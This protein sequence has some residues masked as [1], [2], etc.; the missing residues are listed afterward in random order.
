MN[1]SDRRNKFYIC[2]G[3]GIVEGFYT[4]GKQNIPL[5]GICKIE[6]QR[7]IKKQGHNSLKIDF[8]KPPEGIGVYLSYRSH[9]LKKQINTKIQL[10]PKPSFIFRIKKLKKNDFKYLNY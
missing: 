5:K 2:E 4:D 9:E 6:P 1:L 3:P 8:I 10:R 7:Q